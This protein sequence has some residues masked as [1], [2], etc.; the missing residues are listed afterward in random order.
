LP[1][2]LVVVVV[3][4]VASMSSRITRTVRRVVGTPVDASHVRAIQVEF[5][6]WTAKSK[7]LMKFVKAHV[8]T[9]RFHNP[10]LQFSL[11]RTTAARPA[12]V[13]VQYADGKSVDVEVPAKADALLADVLRRTE[14]PL[15]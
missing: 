8:P 1:P 6:G 15:K 11:S 7:T 14:A 13:T 10:E 9:L 4:V 5:G 2:P 3:V 12:R